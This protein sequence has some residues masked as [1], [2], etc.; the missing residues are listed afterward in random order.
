MASLIKKIRTSSGDCQIDYNALANLPQLNTMFSNPNLLINSDFRN[1][2]NQRG[3]TQVATTAGNWTKQYCIDRWYVQ[4]GTTVNVQDGYI[5][6]SSSSSTSEGYFCQKFEN[7]LPN[8]IYTITIN[9]K[10]IGSGSTVYFKSG[11]NAYG[12]ALTKGINVITLPSPMAMESV[13]IQ[14]HASVTVE[15]YWIKLEQGA[16]STPFTPR[17]IAEELLLCKRYF[18]IYNGN[19]FAVMTQTYTINTET[20]GSVNLSVEMRDKPT[21]TVYSF[22]VHNIDNGTAITI[23]STVGTGESNDVINIKGTHAS[24]TVAP[25]YIYAKFAADAEIY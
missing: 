13:E 18:Q 25:R 15:L 14:L 24:A 16:K 22:D 20:H 8:D 23:N 21:V 2:V 3:K 5:K 9:V 7:A 6:L 1:P 10:S 4:N 12:A 11:T 19:R 17:S